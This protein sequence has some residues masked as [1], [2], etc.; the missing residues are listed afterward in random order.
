MDPHDPAFPNRPEWLK[1]PARRQV[2]DATLQKEIQ[3]RGGYGEVNLWSGRKL[4]P[5]V[6]PV[7]GDKRNASRNKDAAKFR[8]VIEADVGRT[9][10]SDA[11]QHVF[12]LYFAKGCCSH[13]SA[14]T[15]LHRL[16]TAQDEAYAV[17]DLSADVFGREKRAEAEGYRK[18]AGTLERDNRTLYVNYEGAGGYDLP[19][20]RQLLEA[21]FRAFGPLNNIYILHHKTVAFVRYDWRSSAEFAKEAMHKQ[22]LLGS[23]QGEVITARWANEDPNPVAVIAMKRAAEEAFGLA[24]H[25]AFEAL[26]PEQKQARIMELQLQSAVR[27][28]TSIGAYPSTE[29]Q[30]AAREA[31]EAA[32]AA[33]RRRRQEAAA[34]A[35]AAGQGYG[36]E[37]EDDEDIP[38]I[39]A[40]IY[41][42]NQRLLAQRR[43]AQA[44]ASQE[45]P[46]KQPAMNAPQ[47]GQP[48][49]A[50]YPSQRPPVR[51]PAAP[52]LDAGAPGGYEVQGDAGPFAGSG[53]P[54]GPSAAPGAAASGAAPGVGGEGGAG[55]AAAKGVGSGEMTEWERAWHDPEMREKMHADPELR[56]RMRKLRNEAV[57]WSA[58]QAHFHAYAHSYGHHTLAAQHAEAEAAQAQQGE[59]AQGQ[60]QGQGQDPYAAWYGYGYGQQGPGEAAGAGAGAPG[61]VTGY[62]AG[63]GAGYYGWYGQEQQGVEV[64]GVHKGVVLASGSLQ[65]AGVRSGDH[66]VMLQHASVTSMKPS[67]AQDTTPPPTAETIRSAILAEARRR[68][69]ENTIVEPPL[70]ARRYGLPLEAMALDNQL[71]QL[72]QALG[73]R[74]GPLGG[75]V[76]AAGGA[77]APRPGDAIRAAAAAS[78]RQQQ[79]TAAGGGPHRPMAGGGG[80]PPPGLMLFNM[81]PVPPPHAAA[82]PPPPAAPPA[83]A[84]PEPD[85]QAASQLR[86]MG[87]GE[88]VVRKAL[89]LHRNDMEQALNWLL[90]HGDDP[91]AAEPLTDDQLRQIYSRGPRGPPSEPEL[92]EQLVA[93]GFERNQSA[94]ALRHFRNMDLALAYLLR[95]AEEGGAAGDAAAAGAAGAGAAAGGAAAAGAAAA[96]EPGAG[97]GAGERQGVEPAAGGQGAAPAATG[98]EGGGSNQQAGGGAATAG[99]GAALDVPLLASSDG[100]DDEFEDAAQGELPAAQSHEEE[101]E[102][103]SDE[104]DGAEEEEGEEAEGLPGGGAAH[105]R[106]GGPRQQ[107]MEYEEE[108]EEEE[109]DDDDD[110]EY[111]EEDGGEG[112]EG[113]GEEMDSDIDDFQGPTMMEQ[114]AMAR[115]RGAG[116]TVLR[117]PL[118]GGGLGLGA[119]GGGGG[120]V[121]DDGMGPMGAFGALYG[122]AA[123]GVGGAA[124]AIAVTRGPDGNDLVLGSTGANMPPL[125]PARGLM[126]GSGG[127][128]MGGLGGGGPLRA[129]VVD[130]PGLL[131]GGGDGGDGEEEL[132]QGMGLVQQLLNAVLRDALNDGG[133]GGAPGGGGAA[134]GAGPGPL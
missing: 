30:F 67:V 99:G 131:Q 120:G 63:Y 64:Q 19:K 66:L 7:G 48:E 21:N 6:P 101:E 53:E 45:E 98:G 113:E 15:Y 65:Q 95:T 117:V 121:P 59:A 86:E 132:L 61:E 79:A 23:S 14:C 12:C 91:A 88:A 47:P 84:I 55:P 68:G 92:V 46:G 90:Q 85:A 123:H 20:I 60:E 70:G 8:L 50:Q 128:G 78:A 13:G 133:E 24:A 76:G 33:E 18:G 22:S 5:T 42:E 72:I 116:R 10:G 35:A 74:T 11:K 34:A 97:A 40:D 27:K 102:L 49:H 41:Q 112:E 54:G 100:D 56:E 94:A 129:Q 44:A 93:M 110:E 58:Y 82:A 111:E 28:G 31:Q 114:L 71:L 119:A 25:S 37:E 83:L 115:A 62:G 29:D 87:F 105:P 17:R 9:R 103:V 96:A 106:A 109:D 2:D 81:P 75:P 38:Y 43:A 36:Q 52:V 26:P 126:M 130:L 77:G 1:R 73:G 32:M 124:P 39:P 125:M 16:P 107:E 3:A 127:M 51:D 108:G 4:N 69:I 134:R 80:A 104:E 118:G 122:G 89:L 57:Y